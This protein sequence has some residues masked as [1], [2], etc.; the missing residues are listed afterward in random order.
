MVF[1]RTLRYGFFLGLS[2]LIVN[3]HAQSPLPFKQVFSPQIHQT[4]TEN[5][6]QTTIQVEVPEGYYLYAEKTHPR[7]E[8]PAITVTSGKTVTENDAYFGEVEIYDSEHP[9]RFTLD[10][11]NAEDAFILDAQGCLKDVICYPPDSWTLSV[12]HGGEIGAKSSTVLSNTPLTRNTRE[13]FL[14][15][16]PVRSNATTNTPA[17]TST[18]IVSANPPE[19]TARDDRLSERLRGNYWLT[20]PWL[21]LLGIGVS[22]TACVYPLIPIVSSLVVG[23]NRSK[24]RSFALI[25]CYVL[26]MALAMAGLGALFGV[27]QINLQLIFQKPW[28]AL[29][30]A[31]LFVALA[32]SL[33][34][35]F[36]LRAPR[37]LQHWV[38][39]LTRAQQGG[40][41]IGAA[42]LGALSV[43]VV[44]PCATP[45]LTALLLYTTQTT[46]A[47]GALALFCFGLG[48]GL[49]LLLFAT[50]LRQFMPKAG[51]W[52]VVVKKLF[53]FLML[54]IAVWLIARILPPVYRWGSWA[55]YFLI[56]VSTLKTHN[57]P[58]TRTRWLTDMIGNTAL[59]IA[60]A[61][62]VQ[63]A[64]LLRSPDQGENGL[65][66][67][68][69]TPL[70]LPVNN[71][72]ELRAQLS[73]SQ[74]PVI[75][76][77]YADW[78][79]SC[80]VWENDIWHNP[81]FATPLSDYHL[82][83]VDVTA[84]SDAHKA[85]FQ[86]LNLVGPPA[87]LFY[88][89]GAAAENPA[90]TL[91][92]ELSPDEFAEILALQPAQIAGQSIE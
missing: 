2:L 13:N 78:C 3:L 35:V 70:F 63:S 27:L 58:S 45:V 59:V 89:P 29:L 22:L 31:L 9:A 19:I 21:F 74:K 69:S 46:P 34:D 42:V 88:P 23:E 76:D 39:R 86:A 7:T 84:F 80:Q 54:A 12:A 1:L 49:P 33:F 50:A 41:F 37:S 48:T 82:I 83:Q 55:G 8:D 51:L 85:L 53:G 10:H 91:I 24:R 26:A 36:T 81:R 66:R 52:M 14:T 65:S 60:I 87:V 56:L 4:L 43:L 40:S 6:Y 20:L 32:L 30:T 15:S 61:C 11:P 5:G 75:V 92:G 67:T 62:A 72:P 18:K 77:F 79:L 90:K 71:L 25:S 64:T 73:E 28:I 16:Q 68:T 17:D 47:K 44:S 57:S 38:D